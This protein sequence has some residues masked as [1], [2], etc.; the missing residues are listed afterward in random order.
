MLILYLGDLG[1]GIRCLMSLH[2]CLIVK[3]KTGVWLSNVCIRTCLISTRQARLLLV[4]RSILCQL[5]VQDW[6]N[7]RWGRFNNVGVHSIILYKLRYYS[8]HPSKLFQSDIQ[9]QSNIH[10]CGTVGPWYQAIT[11]GI[12]LCT[13]FSDL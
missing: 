13:C 2:H 12:L 11:T 6:L 5:I 3:L 4:C 10:I 1:L 8:M 9:V 7:L